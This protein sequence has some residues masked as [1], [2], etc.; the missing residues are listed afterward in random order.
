MTLGSWAENIGNSQQIAL[1]FDDI[2]VCFEPET[3][4]T[5]PTEGGR[6]AELQVTDSKA[7]LWLPARKVP[8]TGAQSAID[9]EPI[10]R[11]EKA[12]TWDKRIVHVDGEHVFK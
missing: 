9:D 5:F 12:E 1:Y 2:S 7:L 4:A 6:G 11:K 8:P 10:R 3:R